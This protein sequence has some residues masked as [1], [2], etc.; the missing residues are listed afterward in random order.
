[1]KLKVMIAGV[2]A[3]LAFAGSASAACEF[4]PEAQAGQKAAAA[5][6]A[7]H[8]FEED[9][10]SRP[11][12][13]NIATVFGRQAAS[14]EDFTRYSPAMKAAGEKGLVWNE[15]TIPAYVA[16]PKAFLTE[17]NG[18]SMRHGMFFKLGSEEK[19]QQITTYLKELAACEQ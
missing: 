7:C 10:P 11:T 15:E 12:G 19:R 14:R 18:E 1:M 9:K 2:V 13:P 3:G 5:C 4:S 8:L 16:D 6:K 17:F